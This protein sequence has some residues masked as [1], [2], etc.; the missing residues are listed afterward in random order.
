VKQRFRF[1]FD[2]WY[3]RP[4]LRRLEELTTDPHRKYEIRCPVHGFIQIDDWERQIIDQPAFQRLRRIRQLAFTDLLY[5]A[6]MHTRFE[7][8]LGVMH[9]ATLLYD[10][11]VQKSGELLKQQLAYDQDGLARDRRLVRL[12]ALLHDVGHAPFSH[13]SEDLFPKRGRGNEKFT[14][15]DYS[16][17]II[18]NE[19]RSAIEDHPLNGNTGFKADNIAAL[20][21][22]GTEAGRAVF[23]RDLIQGQMD[24]DRMDYLIRDSHHIGVHYGKFDLRRLILSVIAIPRDKDDR[25][26]QLG[27]EEGGW[28]AAE[29][30]VLARYFMFTQVYF[31]KTRV[32]YDIHLREAMKTLLPLGR[33]P[34]P[35][36]A[37][38]K[39][40]LK[41]DDW[42]ILGLIGKGR[43]GEHGRRIIERNH[44]REIY[45]T[46]EVCSDKDDRELRIVKA[47]LGKFVVAQESA[48]K[49]W[50]KTGNTDI[51]VL[52]K[53]RRPRVQPLSKYSKAI[54]GMK[55][56]NQ[57]L[58]Y[59]D[60]ADREEAEKRIRK[61]RQQK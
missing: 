32:A 39:E 42:R 14:H 10:S 27:I 56:N 26:P 11:I 40:F 29:A 44:F 22:K 8:S 6:A 54:E 43:A 16:A 28:H 47:K 7:H 2:L 48:K 23:W 25:S 55:E 51:P 60:G 24:A 20:I 21:G 59:V 45:H 15:E 1:F 33:F 3:N 19:L 18:R 12:A 49:S 58:L 5:P 9:T 50:Y 30:L 46:P 36:G 4:F 17:A 57:V 52:S 37:E 61:G 41:W 38:L 34:K 13:S 31:H 35:E 53:V